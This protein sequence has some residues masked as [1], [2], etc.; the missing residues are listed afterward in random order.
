[1]ATW[2]DAFSY[3]TQKYKNDDDKWI[4]LEINGYLSL[5]VDENNVIEMWKEVMV[6]NECIIDG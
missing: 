4:D 6:T 3:S 2:L 5:F 1:M